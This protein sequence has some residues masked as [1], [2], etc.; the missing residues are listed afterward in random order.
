MRYDQSEEVSFAEIETLKAYLSGDPG[1]GAVEE[2]AATVIRRKL[3]PNRTINGG[4]GAAPN[5]C[6]SRLCRKKI[7]ARAPNAGILV[8]YLG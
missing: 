1:N 5:C 6:A 8:A 7:N 4:L 2:I 3:N